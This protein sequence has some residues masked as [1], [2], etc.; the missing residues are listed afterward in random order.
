M[1]NFHSV[2]YNV[3]TDAVKSSSRQC[4]CYSLLH[5]LEGKDSPRPI[6]YAYGS[7]GPKEAIDL[8]KRVG[9]VHS[10]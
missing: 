5:Y 9:F 6:D 8:E 7:A 4:A 2:S 10:E 3:A 1:G